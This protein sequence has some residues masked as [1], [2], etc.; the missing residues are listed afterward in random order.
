MTR[1][2]PTREESAELFSGPKRKARTLAGR[3][4]KR[5]L[6][7][8]DLSYDFDRGSRSEKGEGDKWDG[9]NETKQMHG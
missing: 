3:G 5:L 1:S 2:E 6:S 8:P 9:K 4:E 7:D